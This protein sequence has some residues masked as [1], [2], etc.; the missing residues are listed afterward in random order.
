MADRIPL[1]Y[2]RAKVN[3]DATP[4]VVDDPISKN[5]GRTS[6]DSDSTALVGLGSILNREA[7]NDG[8]L[9]FSCH[10]FNDCAAS[11]A[12]DDRRFRSAF[13]LDRNPLPA[14]IDVLPV[15]TR[16]DK[17]GIAVC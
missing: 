9:V 13:A 17:N 8:T 3:G 15:R 11:A 4:E 16:A 10:E 1:N 12:V 2:R 5:F 7:P 14:E 6:A